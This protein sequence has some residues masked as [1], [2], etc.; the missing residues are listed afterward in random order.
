MRR[1]VGVVL[2]A[3]GALLF[4]AAPLMRWYAYPQLAVTP[5]DTEMTTV[6]FGENVRILDVGAVAAGRSAPERVTDITS[7][8]G[9]ISV[10]DGPEGTVSDDDVAVWHTL[11]NNTDGRGQTISATESVVAFDR[12]TGA[13]VPGYSQ[14]VDGDPVEHEGQVLKFPFGTEKRDYEFWDATLRAPTPAVYDGEDEIEGLTVYR[15]VQTIEPTVVERVEVPG[16]LAGSEQ[17]VIEAE[18]VYVNTRTLWVEPN[19]GVIIRG[20]EEQDS[21]LAY[22][23]VQIATV[24]SGTLTYTD[25]TVSELVDRYGD[26][27]SQLNL[28]RT[29]LPVGLGI[30]GLVLL[31]LGVLLLA[32]RTPREGERTRSTGRHAPDGGTQ[33]DE[34]DDT[35]ILD[36]DARERAQ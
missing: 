21:L 8:R 9:T 25:E 12:H 3:V 5:H 24:T 31:V 11:V 15:F 32:P 20:Q 22:N 33:P 10:V 28:V 35:S 23:G 2:I 4:L 17:D 18:R 7:T 27:A 13:G 34:A 16:S 36:F 14:T 1:K 30:A 26:T 29:T 19:T 6:S